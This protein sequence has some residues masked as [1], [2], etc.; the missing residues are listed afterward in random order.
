MGVKY[1]LLF[2]GWTNSHSGKRKIGEI[3]NKSA[4]FEQNP[5]VW[6]YTVDLGA[7]RPRQDR[8]KWLSGGPP[9]EQKGLP[10]KQSFCFFLD[11]LGGVQSYTS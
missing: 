9:N 8:S 6:E 3:R 1:L 11:V 7:A 2:V 10:M 5:S 4:S